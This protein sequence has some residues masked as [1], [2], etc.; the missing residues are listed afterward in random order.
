MNGAASSMPI[1]SEA[2]LLSRDLSPR[3]FILEL[4]RWLDMRMGVEPEGVERETFVWALVAAGQLLPAMATVARTLERAR[5]FV[6]EPT[7]ARYD[8]LISAATNSYPFGPGEGC[9]AIKELGYVGCE[10]GSGCLSGSGSLANV[11]GAIG[12]ERTAEAIRSALRA[13]LTARN[14]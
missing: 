10:P 2:E 7:E 8:A 14:G 12:Y 4:V 6:A 11:A 9:F 13:R 3:E 5:A 1:F